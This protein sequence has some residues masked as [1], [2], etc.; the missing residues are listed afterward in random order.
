MTYTGLHQVNKLQSSPE[1]PASD[2]RD[3]KF[4]GGLTLS[5]ASTA[6]KK[7]LQALRTIL[8]WKVHL[9]IMLPAY[10]AIFI[11]KS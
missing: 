4:V 10:L 2:P 9:N 7:S 6:L 11:W 5:L 8:L 1:L 3:D